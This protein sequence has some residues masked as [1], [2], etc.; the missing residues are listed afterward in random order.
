VQGRHVDPRLPRPIVQTALALVH[1]LLALT[2]LALALI[3]LALALIRLAL[4]LI[5]PA[6]ALI[7]HGLTAVGLAFPRVSLVFP[8]VSRALTGSLSPLGRCGVRP[9]TLPLVLHHP[10]IYPAS[11][12]RIP[13]P[14]A[15]A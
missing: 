13:D 5:R 12:A 14:P 7:R 15:T 10:M 1:L 9:L 6:L 4:A 11:G 8:L 2:G 3:R